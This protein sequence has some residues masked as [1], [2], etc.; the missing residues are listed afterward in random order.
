MESAESQRNAAATLFCSSPINWLLRRIQRM[1][2]EGNAVQ[3]LVLER[4]NPF[5]VCCRDLFSILAQPLG[6]EL[7]MDWSG[8]VCLHHHMR[9]HND[10]DRLQ[11][12]R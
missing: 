3:D 10:A 2:V 1:D 4:L 12:C 5:S 8:S 9:F 7:Q 11:F 6:G